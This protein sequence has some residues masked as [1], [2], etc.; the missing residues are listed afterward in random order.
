MSHN[1]P[2]SKTEVEYKD[3]RRGTRDRR[4]G[5]LPDGKKIYTDQRKGQRD[6]R[7]PTDDR[8]IAVVTS[9]GEYKGTINLNSAPVKVERVSDFFIKSDFSF[10]LLY[11]TTFFGKPGKTAF[12]NLNDIAVV[13]QPDNAL[14]KRSELRH[15]AILSVRLRY[16]LGQVNGKVNLRGETMPVDR[17]SDLLNYSKKRWL[18]VYEATFKGRTM[19]STIINMDFISMVWVEK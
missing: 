7:M 4:G 17:V 1:R 12:L 18:V 9:T 11:N 5:E 6:R 15:D 2:S 3:R 10:L 19:L 16:G 8:D 13:I 14:S